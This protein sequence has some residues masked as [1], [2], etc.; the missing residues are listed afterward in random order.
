MKPSG[1]RDFGRFGSIKTRL[2]ALYAGLFACTLIALAV[3]TQAIIVSHAKSGVHAQMAAVSSA[4]ERV[5]GLRDRMLESSIDVMA[6]DFGFRS[7]VATGDTAT[8]ASALDNLAARAGVET[9][10]LIDLDGR[11]VGEASDDL[12]ARLSAPDQVTGEVVAV[13]RDAYRV[14]ATPVLAPVPIGTVVLAARIDATDLALVRSLA[15]VPLDATLMMRE[16][17][18]RWHATGGATLPGVE[19][20]DPV[21]LEVA[22][23]PTVIAGHKLRSSDERS[24]VAIMLS[25]PL[26]AALAD[27]R[28]L[29]SAILV[30]GLAS[31]AMFLLGSWF[32]ARG[33][34][35]PILALDGA[36]RAI[37]AGDRQLVQCRTDDEIG[38]LAQSFNEM[39]GAIG[40]HEARIAHMAFNDALTG[41][42]NRVLFR[43]QLDAGLKQA[44]ARH[45]EIALLCIDLDGFK[46]INDTLGHPFGDR[47]LA[48]IAGMLVD[49][50][51]GNLV[52][53]LGGD[54]FAI[55]VQ[56]AGGTAALQALANRIIAA[57]HEPIMLDEQQAIIGA[58]IGMAVGPVDGSDADTLLKSADLSLY[59]AKDDGRGVTRFFEPWLDAEAQQ[60]RQMEIDLRTALVEGQFVLHYQP[61]FDTQHERIVCFEALLRWQHPINGLIAPDRFIPLAEE[62][63]LILQIG[64]WV[65]RQACQQA[66]E[67]PDEIRIAVNVSPMQ[68][69]NLGL[70]AVI[71]QALAN[72]GLRPGRLEIEITESIFLESSDATIEML[73]SLHRLGI[74]IALDDFGIGYS[75]LSYLRSF[76]FDKIKIDR[77]FVGSLDSNTTAGAIIDAIVRLARALGMETTAEG[78]ETAD[79]LA[80][81]RTQGCSSVQGFLFSRPVSGM[82]AG[83]LA[84]GSLNLAQ[85]A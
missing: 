71:L 83:I 5:W 26:G 60:R 30:A 68:F 7:A 55:I 8:I 76:P 77:S 11:I 63:G 12:R 39:V 44:V 19:R 45:E 49:L 9:A 23:R 50:A 24:Q 75:S 17:G 79:Q 25:Y 80:Q 78:V 4:Y 13:G 38:R 35:R 37:A 15:A 73:H 31:M 62:S 81:V 10:L 29:Q 51:P 54:E 18:G 59:R 43:E 72:S 48:R 1:L 61:I 69:R 57:L 56:N 34:T 6:R 84:R 22:G 74:R 53:R 42:P 46:A 28:P 85:V 67:W 64:E 70:N 3:I 65:L 58:S 36:A 14:I 66:R 41:L 27:F 52:A 21:T 33:I 2:V 20:L 40:E 47:L 32:V 82:E 16:A